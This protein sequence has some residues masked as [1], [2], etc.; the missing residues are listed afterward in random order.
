MHSIHLVGSFAV[1]SVCPI[2]AVAIVLDF[3]CIDIL[4]IGREAF[5]GFPYNISKSSQLGDRAL[6]GC[7]LISA[8]ILQG[9]VALPW[10]LGSELFQILIAVASIL[11]G[12]LWQ[13]FVLLKTNNRS[14]TKMDTY[15]NVFIAPLFMYLLV[16]GLPVIYIYGSIHEKGLT[17]LFILLWIELVAYDAKNGRLDQCDWL[18]RNQPGLKLIN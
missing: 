13:V 11:T 18:R 1:L 3:L 15:H 2:W 5:E 16:T 9:R 4:Y 8:T 7:A 12:I 6:I 17:G 14:V 10:W